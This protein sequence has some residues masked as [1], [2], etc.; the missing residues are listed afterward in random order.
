MTTCEFTSWRATAPPTGDLVPNATIISYMGWDANLTP[1]GLDIV[2]DGIAADID[3]PF[4]AMKYCF[5]RWGL[6]GLVRGQWPLAPLSLPAGDASEVKWKLAGQTGDGADIEPFEYA[7]GWWAIDL[8]GLQPVGWTEDSVLQ[9][10]WTA[11]LAGIPAE[12]TGA[13][14]HLFS[15]VWASRQDHVPGRVADALDN[16]RSLLAR[17]DRNLGW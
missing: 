11:G 6:R 4:G 15:A 2:K 17:Y 12:V 10:D 1:A 16:V 7:P 14:M 3:G 5:R 13:Y 9:V 8:L